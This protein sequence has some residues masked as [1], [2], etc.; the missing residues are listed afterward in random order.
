MAL[1]RVKKVPTANLVQGSS[2][3]T[4]ASSLAAARFPAGTV[5]QTVFDTHDTQ[6]STNQ[7]ASYIDTGL[8]ATITPT[9]ASNKILVSVFQNGVYK[10][11]SAAAGCEIRLLRGSTVI[12]SLSKRAGGD[13]GTGTAATMSV[14]TVGNQVLDTPS[15][16]SATTYKTQFMSASNASTVYVQVYTCDSTIVLQEI[17]V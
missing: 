14:G 15:T 3:L 17:V 1:T 7:N 8:E 11:G 4:S 5:I 13:N 2:F 9:S 6:V 10:D 12:S 16:T